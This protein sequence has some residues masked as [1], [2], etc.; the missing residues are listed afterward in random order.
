[1]SISIYRYIEIDRERE[2]ERES[3]QV[4]LGVWTVGKVQGPRSR[5]L[6]SAQ[7]HS[8]SEVVAGAEEHSNSI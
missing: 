3:K 4:E 7:G 1:M 8:A 6:S 2:R 5:G